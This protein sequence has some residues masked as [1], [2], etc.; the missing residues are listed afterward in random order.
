[1][2]IEVS[3][4]RVWPVV[5]R[6]ARAVSGHATT[7]LLKNL[8]NSRRLMGF[9]PVAEN[10]LRKKSNTIFERELCNRIAGKRIT[11]LCD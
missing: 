8:M 9:T 5:A 4:E 3:F 10:H 6:S 7:M 1:V 11:P 2:G